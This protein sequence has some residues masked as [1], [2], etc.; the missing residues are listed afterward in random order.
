M[1][2]RGL[3]FFNLGE[4][5]PA[6]ESYSR[7]ISLNPDRVD[8]Y[9]LRGT[10]YR[11]LEEYGRAIDDFDEAIRLDPGIA[12]AFLNRGVAYSNIDDHTKAIADFDEAL[13]LDPDLSAASEL[14]AASQQLS[15]IASQRADL[16]DTPPAGAEPS[17]ALTDIGGNWN[18]TDTSFGTVTF[19]SIITGSI[20]APYLGATFLSYSGRIVGTMQGNMF[21]GVW[22][23]D[24]SAVNCD[25][26]VENSINWGK[27]ELSFDADATSFEGEWGYCDDRPTWQFNG[28]RS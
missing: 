24:G 10:A 15:E 28:T 25:S 6:V 20:T 7:A 17:I 2:D 22:V 9:S 23:Q 5:R 16:N 21:T 27:V 1:A 14:R 4:Y 12:L 11:N 18:T 26:F 3:S 19:P 8:Y 13:S